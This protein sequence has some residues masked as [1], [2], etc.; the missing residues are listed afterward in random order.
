[1]VMNF[2]T[3]ETPR[4]MAF[5]V[6]SNRY[7]GQSTRSTG[8]RARAS[9]AT[10]Q[11]GIEQQRVYRVRQ[12]WGFGPERVVAFLRSRCPQWGVSRP[13]QA[14]NRCFEGSMVASQPTASR[15]MG[16]V[17]VNFRKS[18]LWLARCGEV[19]DCSC[20]GLPSAARCPSSVPSH[21]ASRQLVV[22]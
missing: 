13:Y 10:D 20:P 15:V 12:P 11:C 1:M 5:C 22:Q 16:W 18:F 17:S 9:A 21:D 4:C 3:V 19:G 2:G 14:G 8:Q 7:A 6:L